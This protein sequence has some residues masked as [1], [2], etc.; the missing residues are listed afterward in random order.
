VAVL[1]WGTNRNF[2][3]FNFKG[4]FE[5]IRHLKIDPSEQTKS[6]KK[7]ISLCINLILSRGTV[8]FDHFCETEKYIKTIVIY[9]NVKN[10]KKLN[11]KK[12]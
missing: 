11:I 7:F 8:S 1:N 10:W 5:Q 3:Q 4:W 6:D 9:I 12:F 2:L